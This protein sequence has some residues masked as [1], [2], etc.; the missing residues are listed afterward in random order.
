MSDKIVKDNWSILEQTINAIHTKSHSLQGFGELLQVAHNIIKAKGEDTFYN[1]AKK[2]TE[3]HMKPIV[4][5]L[6]QQTQNEDLL[7]EICKDWEFLK[8]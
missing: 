6:L 5:R 8:F 1:E 7:S 4:K 3:F 2:I